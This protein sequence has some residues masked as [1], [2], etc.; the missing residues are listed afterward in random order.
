M[1]EKHCSGAVCSLWFDASITLSENNNFVLQQPA[2]CGLTQVNHNLKKLKP[3]P[4][5]WGSLHFVFDLS[6]VQ[7]QE[8]KGI[9]DIVLEQSSIFV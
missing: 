5:F 1:S 2:V 4:L 8:D 7:S 9:K 6:V 3:K